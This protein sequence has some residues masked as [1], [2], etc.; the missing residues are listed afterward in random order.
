MRTEIG[1]YAMDA[2]RGPI[3]FEEYQAAGKL[4]GG[5]LDLTLVRIAEA[6]RDSPVTDDRAPWAFPGEDVTAF[7]F[8]RWKL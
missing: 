4:L 3:T 5:L 2:T 6:K 1:T 7:T 8:G